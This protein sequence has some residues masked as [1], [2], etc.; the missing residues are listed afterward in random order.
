MVV[1]QVRVLRAHSALVEDRSQLT[2]AL[3]SQVQFQWT[4]C[5]LAPLGSCTSGTHELV[6][7]H[8]RIKKLETSKPQFEENLKK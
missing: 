8:M 1:L 5:L 7:I 6:H 4:Q 2:A 3:S